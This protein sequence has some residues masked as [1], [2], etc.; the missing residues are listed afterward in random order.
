MSEFDQWKERLDAY[1]SPVPSRLW[2]GVASA[3]QRKNNRRFVAFWMFGLGLVAIA[4]VYGWIRTPNQNDPR[5]ESSVQFYQITNQN[6]SESDDAL[7]N[8]KIKE[9]ARSVVGTPNNQTHT[10]QDGNANYSSVVG[11]QK[12]NENLV[13]AVLSKS[14]NQSVPSR[15]F[16]LRSSPQ[17]KNENT[18]YL[19]N[20]VDKDDT[21]RSLDKPEAIENRRLDRPVQPLA[22]Y[23]ISDVEPR[24]EF[25]PVDRCDL[26]DPP[27]GCP[28][29]GK[30]SGLGGGLSKWAFDLTYGPGL[31]LRRLTARSGE[32]ESYSNLRE[33]NETA[34][35]D[36]MI[37]ARVSYISKWGIS[38]RTGLNYAHLVEKLAFTRDSVTGST[39]TI[40][41]DT[42]FNPDGSFS[43]TRDT[44]NVVTSGRLEKV[45][46]NHFTTLQIPIVLGYEHR[47]K[48]WTFHLN[49]GVLMNIYLN[50]R[51]EILD[52][53]DRPVDI[54]SSS[55]SF[56]AF[57]DGWDMIL[58]G[59]LGA[60]YRIS[61]R[62]HA[63]IE[64]SFRYTLNPITT[65]NYPL[66]Q[67]Y[68][69]LN[70]NFGLRYEF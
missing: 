6:Q 26:P 45:K 69:I 46:Y 14:H 47:T 54:S 13:N 24:I 34:V 43:I 53:A 21:P 57:K 22:T 11:T 2:E 10:D 19:T 32:F 58:F 59:S 28:K 64:P 60:N 61:D 55:G 65:V 70:L 68:I 52:Q 1:E 3:I 37:Q 5:Y 41:I 15:S 66:E 7:Q 51:G 23:G 38:A 27:I 20:E 48:D 36:E 8:Q 44:S 17:Q 31:P 67:K 49:G 40:T 4:L 12:S 9:E 39:T 16:S 35:Y 62:L 50:R 29:L 30:R 42:V 56:D 18:N 25:I 63:V 33:A